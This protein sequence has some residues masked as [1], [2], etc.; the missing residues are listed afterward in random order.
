MWKTNHCLDYWLILTRGER[1]VLGREAGRAASYL[2][3]SRWVH[4]TYPVNKRG[5]VCPAGS[6]WTVRFWHKHEVFS[7]G[8]ARILESFSTGS[9]KQN[10][11]PSKLLSLPSDYH[12]S[13]MRTSAKRASPLCDGQCFFIPWSQNEGVLW[14]KK[15]VGLMI[16]M[17]GEE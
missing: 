11:R 2:L 1:V 7:K 12:F 16:C 6:L 14:P 4:I 3:L 17:G 8:V 5:A 15:H 10:V 9:R 13:D